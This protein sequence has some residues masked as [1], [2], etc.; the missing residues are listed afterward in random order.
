MNY[1]LLFAAI[2]PVALFSSCAVNQGNTSIQ[3]FGR[4]AELERGKSTKRDVYKG[5]G[6][7]HDVSYASQNSQWT[8]YNTQSTTSAAS[9]IPFVGLVAGGL[10][11]QI[12]TADFFF[13]KKD[14]LQRYSTSQRTKFVNSFVGVAQGVGSLASNKQSNRVKA[15]MDKLKRKRG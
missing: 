13:N 4:F 1:K 8:F 9:F 14:V 3:D 2:L 5:F 7:P 15:E 11:N 12:T 6:Q 10:N